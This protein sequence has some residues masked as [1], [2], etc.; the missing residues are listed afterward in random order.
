MRLT[1]QIYHPAE[2]SAGLLSY[3]DSISVIVHSGQMF[4]Y[5]RRPPGEFASF[6]QSCIARWYS[7]AFVTVKEELY[8]DVEATVCKD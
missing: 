1:F 7:G 5:Y 2:P 6:M 3:S 4:G 8:G